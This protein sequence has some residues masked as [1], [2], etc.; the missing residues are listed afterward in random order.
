MRMSRVVFRN[1]HS[2]AYV[3][4]GGLYATER[5]FDF[6][7]DSITAKIKIRHTKQCSAGCMA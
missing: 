1:T 5:I 3:S 6:S 2:G 7:L 4:L